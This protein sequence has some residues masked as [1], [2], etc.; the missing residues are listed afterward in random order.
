[1]NYTQSVEYIHSLLAFGIK[2]GLERIRMLLKFLG[3]PQDKI[4]T[5]HVAGTN[6]KG[7]TSTMIAN[8][9]ICDGHKTGLFVSPYVISFCERIQIDGKNV[10]GEFLA[11]RVT[12]VREKIEELNKNNIIIT[13]FEAITAAAFLC[14]YES[15]CDCAVI[16]VG[17]GGRFDATNVL[18]A[19]ETVVITS[20]SLDHTAILGDTVSKIAF[21]KCGIIKNGSKVITSLNQTDDAIMVIEQ[22]VSE[23]GGKLIKTDPQRAKIISESILGT[24][25]LYNEEKYKIT[26]AGEHQIENAVNAIE[27]AKAIGVSSKAIKDGISKTRMTA[28]MEIIGNDP[29]VIRDGGHNEGCSLALRNYLLKNNVKNIR[30]LI[31]MMADKD[32]ESYIKNIVPLCKSVMTVTPSNPRAMDGKDLMKIAQKYCDNCEFISD[33]KE[34]YDRLILTSE[35]DDTVLVCGSFYL[36]SDIF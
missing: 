29:L 2:P 18:K 30:L 25:F 3:D 12:K 1:M 9:L 27:A 31:G 8:A 14:F 26:L 4:K 13:E 34:A 21:E 16:E 23:R 22:T 15:G 36:I 19:P 28:R 35:K 5:V 32:T 20:I 10:D 7:S 11:Q 33:P 6:G 24:E 17:L